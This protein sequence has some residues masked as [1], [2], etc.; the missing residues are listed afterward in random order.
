MPIKLPLYRTDHFELVHLQD[1]WN[2]KFKLFLRYIIPLSKTAIHLFM[3]LFSPNILHTFAS[4]DSRKHLSFS[5]M[6]FDVETRRLILHALLTTCMDL[7]LLTNKQIVCCGNFDLANKP[8]KRPEN[9]VDNNELKAIVW[10][11]PS[12]TMAELA[13]AFDVNVKIILEYLRKI[14]KI[15][16]LD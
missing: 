3:C 7:T 5:N 1:E 4:M 16:R 13:S 10:A 14:G 12:L 8:R 6:R 11:D 2:S 9:S 15:K